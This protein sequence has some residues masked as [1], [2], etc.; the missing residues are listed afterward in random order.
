MY[1]KIRPLVSG[2]KRNFRIRLVPY[3]GKTCFLIMRAGYE[4]YFVAYAL[5]YAYIK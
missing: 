1:V 5:D 4:R 2:R 3:I